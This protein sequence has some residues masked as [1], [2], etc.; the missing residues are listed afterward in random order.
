[1]Y[2]EPS[3]MTDSGYRFGRGHVGERC[4]VGEMSQPG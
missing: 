1:V 2:G 3:S 4:A